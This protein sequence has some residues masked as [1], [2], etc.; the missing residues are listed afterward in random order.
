MNNQIFELIERQFQHVLETEGTDFIHQLRRCLQVLKREPLVAPH[1]D[2]LQRE[3]REAEARFK[4]ETAALLPQIVALREE[5]GRLEPELAD[6]CGSHSGPNEAD[7]EWITS[8]HAFDAI[9]A[10]EDIGGPLDSRGRDTSRGR[11]LLNMLRSNLTCVQ[12]RNNLQAQIEEL[13][14]R[15]SDLEELY[16]REW[17]LYV[18]ALAVHPGV[19]LAYLE[20]L[21][22][23]MNPPARV[24]EER[25]S[26]TLEYRDAIARELF[27]G[28]GVSKLKAALYEGNATLADSGKQVIDRCKPFVL[29][30]QVDLLRRVGTR[31]SLE[32]L[33]NR[34][35]LRCE[36]H[37]RE[38]LRQLADPASRPEDVLRDQL[39][40]WL[41][42]Q[43]LTPVTEP[44]IGNLRPDLLDPGA[45][46]VEAK[47][48]DDN[49]PKTKLIRGMYQVYDTFR[50]LRAAHPEVTEGFYIVFRRA[51]PL[52][53]FPPA[54][55]SVEEGW[56]VHIKLIDLAVDG[57]GSEQKRMPIS[58]S[59]VEL[60]PTGHAPPE[61]TTGAPTST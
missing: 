55:R 49:S 42:D 45:I 37:D 18:D 58:I 8:L 54:V 14:A 3:T 21:L 1:I 19:A 32:S 13:D 28:G 44:R 16:D 33:F 36:Q 41:F 30:L 40:M 52:V 46:Y 43:G 27:W 9:I 17:R 10:E 56:T 34:Y 35:Q 24:G 5:L 48:Y 47:Q 2:D 23:V 39:A 53:I 4:M 22:S 15:C 29:T 60:L 31:I 20:E 26:T 6:A 51:G 38:R 59:P 12:E 7:L 11:S 50:R 25:P 57:I 61:K